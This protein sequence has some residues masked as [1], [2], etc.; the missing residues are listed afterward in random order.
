[1]ASLIGSLSKWPLVRQVRE[2][3]DDSD[4]GGMG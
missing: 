2:Q 1:M 4:I 3:A